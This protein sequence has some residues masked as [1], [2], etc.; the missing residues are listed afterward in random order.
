MTFI[1]ETCIQLDL[2]LP[3]SEYSAEELHRR[4]VQ[5]GENKIRSLEHV[6]AHNP[7]NHPAE[8]IEKLKVRLARAKADLE[9][10]R[11]TGE[12]RQIH[13]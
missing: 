3:L 12:Y 13:V 7:Q 8:H 2:E 10:M 5:D 4:N 11:H 1:L 9:H 6:I